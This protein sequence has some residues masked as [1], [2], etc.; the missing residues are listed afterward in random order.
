MKLYPVINDTDGPAY[1][2]PTVLCAITGKP[3]SEVIKSIKDYRAAEAARLAF[4][5]KRN[6]K[7]A[8]V[9]AQHA[10]RA[11]AEVTG[12][13]DIDIEIALSQLGGHGFGFST[14][15]EYPDLSGPVL[16]AWVS[17]KTH[18]TSDII[19]HLCNGDA[20]LLAIGRGD[21]PENPK[22][23]HW[24]IFTKEEF[25][26]TSTDGNPVP[27]DNGLNLFAGNRVNEV[28]LITDDHEAEM[29]FRAALDKTMEEHP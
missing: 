7:L 3:L 1:C 24:I 9:A 23:G 19:E 5:A 18:L 17:N 22:V 28:Y 10:D 16:D 4:W 27:V 20:V 11:K 13:V 25:L 21:D 6:P 8:E 2:G 26:D 15:V 29:A 14:V 12:T